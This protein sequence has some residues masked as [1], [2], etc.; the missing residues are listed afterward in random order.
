MLHH[1]GV[2]KVELLLL[3]RLPFLRAAR[4]PAPEPLGLRAGEWVEVKSMKEVLQTLDLHGCH[5]GLAFSND[6]YGFCGQRLLVQSRVQTILAEETGRVRTVQ[7]TVILAGT[8]C[9][10]Y[11]GC[12]RQM[13]LL[14]REAWLKRVDSPFP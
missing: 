4:N 13:P 10:K 11:M 2:R 8:T 9:R 5:K 3:T 7:D 6:M 12:A 1:A 14:W